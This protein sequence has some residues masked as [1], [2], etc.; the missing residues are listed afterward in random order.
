MDGRWQIARV[1]RLALARI[2]ERFATEY[3][4]DQREHW[5]EIR[6]AEL[7]APVQSALLARWPIYRRL[8]S[9]FKEAHDLRCRGQNL[10]AISGRLV[11]FSELVAG[12]ETHLCRAILGKGRRFRQCE[13]ARWKSYATF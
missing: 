12:R 10:V 6:L 3:S 13:F 7:R 9:R 1:C 11:R 5:S 8:V 4:C 2:Y